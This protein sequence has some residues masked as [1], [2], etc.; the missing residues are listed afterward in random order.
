MANESEACRLCSSTEIHRL[1]Q[2]LLDQEDIE[3]LKASLALATDLS[4]IS[5]QPAYICDQC[6]NV[7]QRFIKLK[8][9]N[10]LPG[11]DCE[12]WAKKY[13]KNRKSRLF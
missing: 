5:I 2:P 9:V 7:T 3:H 12:K 8:N 11:S 10:Q 1:Y 4:D 6:D 13:I